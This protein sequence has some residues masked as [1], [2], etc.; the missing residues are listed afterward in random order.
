MVQAYGGS[1]RGGFCMFKNASW[2]FSCSVV[3][4]KGHGQGGLGLNQEIP[5]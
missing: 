5:K 4:P 3:K 1:E 2:W